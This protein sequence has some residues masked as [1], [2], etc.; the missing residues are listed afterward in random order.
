MALTVEASRAR[1]DLSRPLFI[2][3]ALVLVALVALPVGWLVVTSFLGP[4]GFTL[5]NYAQLVRDP[6][7]RK[8]LW[9]TLWS[10]ACT[11]AAC[12]VVAV[13]M[14][15]LVA[16]TDM[17]LRRTVRIAVLASFVTPPFLGAIAWQLLAEPHAGFLNKLAQTL[18]G[19]DVHPF[20]V[21]TVWGLVFVNFLY[22]FPYVFT[23]VANALERVPSE[24]EDA[25]AILGAG[26]LRTALGVTLPLILP[27]ILAGAL[28]AFLQSLTVFG[29]AAII[30][31]PAGF[32]TMTT[33]IWSLFQF[34]PNPGLAAAAAM[35][36]I[37]LTVLLLRA[38]QAILGRRGYAVVAGKG[39]RR[40]IAP[41]RRWRWPALALCGL[42]LLCALVLPYAALLDA[43]FVKI[44]PALP[45]PANFTLQHVR[46]VFG[47][48]DATP[49]AL[50]NTIVLALGAASIGT[51][52]AVLV[53]Y[54]TQR[55]AIAGWRTLAFFAN[56]PI[57]IPSIVL[58]VGIFLAYTRPPFVLF[59]TLWI[60]LIAFVTIELPAAY[61]QL[62][63][64]TASIHPELEEA[65]RILGASRLRALRDLVAPLMRSAMIATWCFVFIGAIREISA[66]IL[67]FT[68]PTRTISV[69][70]YDLN[71]SGDT[72]SIAVLGLLL[73][74]VTFVVLLVATRVPVA[75][76]ASL[77]LRE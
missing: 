50:K 53:A 1:V 40:S 44:A 38:Q 20:N 14:G 27:S 10:S 56:A 22:T 45:T 73:M 16:R 66:A 46:F 39:A 74:A 18:F 48:L 9:I 23:L 11:A 31:L 30:T 71:E 76:T 51:V 19:P 68:A 28:V 61:Q 54:V 42:V 69:V 7:M 49:V 2:V 15:W 65:G 58:G 59:G 72:G 33:R 62:V 37:V 4:H 60:L 47:D 13:P 24:L 77:E 75:A 5:A 63:A 41:L 57:A 3:V 21:Y 70:I 8:P 67:L 52:L 17:P 12:V 43:A 64:A 29:S 55:R 6:T 36:L 25:S 34:P 32:Y 26:P 35:P